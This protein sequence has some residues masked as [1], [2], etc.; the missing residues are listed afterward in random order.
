MPQALRDIDAEL[1]QQPADH[2]DEL[3]ALTNEEVAGTM[4]SA[5]Q[6][7]SASAASVL[8]R[9]TYGLNV[10]RRHE[11]HRMAQSGQLARPV[12]LVP[13]ASIPIRQGASL[14][15]KGTT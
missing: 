11:P 5:S 1:G 9:F 12:W 10:G 3:R 2:V 4:K 13:Q 8:P 14:R 15:K 6:I 7:A